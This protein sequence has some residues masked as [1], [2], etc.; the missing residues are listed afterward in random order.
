MQVLKSLLPKLH[1]YLL[2]QLTRWQVNSLPPYSAPFP[3]NEGNVTVRY[4]GANNLSV[5]GAT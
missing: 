5:I 4:A 3:D 1:L 2:V